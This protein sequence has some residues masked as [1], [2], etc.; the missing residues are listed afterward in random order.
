MIRLPYPLFH[1]LADLTEGFRGAI[2]DVEKRMEKT[3]DE[4][5]GWKQGLP[6]PLCRLPTIGIDGVRGIMRVERL[7][8]LSKD[9]LGCFQI[10]LSSRWGNRCPQ[11]TV[12]T[13][14][15]GD[16]DALAFQPTMLFIG[17]Q[18]RG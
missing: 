3:Q 8:L 16:I 5:H 13:R 2:A 18:I 15:R 11:N 7:G 12:L 17:D 9:A 1:A 6:R 14:R 4:R 10:S